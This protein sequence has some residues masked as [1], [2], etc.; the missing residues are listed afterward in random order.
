G[1]HLEPRNTR[2]RMSQLVRQPIAEK[3]I[4]LVPAAVHEGQHGDSE[5]RPRQRIQIKMWRRFSAGWWRK[6]PL[7]DHSRGRVLHNPGRL[8]R[9]KTEH[10]SILADGDLNSERV[11]LPFRFEVL[12]EPGSKLA[13]LATDD[14][15]QARIERFLLVEDRD[16]DR[17]FL[18]QVSAA[19][20]RLAHGVPEEI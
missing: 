2:E 18:Q 3:L 16:S 7:P 10:R 8:A 4:S 6:L 14:R 11:G 17:V 20:D 15:I 1:H 5:R 13:R 12:S 9:G 19:T